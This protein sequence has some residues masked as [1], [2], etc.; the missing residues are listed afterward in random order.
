MWTVTV[1]GGGGPE[2]DI[3][4]GTSGSVSISFSGYT[5]SAR[6]IPV[7]LNFSRFGEPV[8]RFAIKRSFSRSPLPQFFKTLSWDVRLCDG[9]EGGSGWICLPVFIT[10]TALC[11]NHRSDLLHR[12]MY[13]G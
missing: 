1:G 6:F 11:G 5:A 12:T 3:R 8:Y 7:L 10:V 9:R 13:F 2:Y 4:T